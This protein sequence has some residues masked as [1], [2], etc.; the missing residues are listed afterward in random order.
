MVFGIFLFLFIETAPAIQAHSLAEFL[1]SGIW[2][3]TSGQ[4]SLLPML[5]GSMLCS[6]LALLIAI[7]ISVLTA[8]FIC[9]LS[10]KWLSNL[11]T[12]LTE[13]M[14]ATPSVVY[15]VWGLV[16]LVPLI[17]SIRAPGTSLITGS[18]I[19]ATMLIPTLVLQIRVDFAHTSKELRKACA[20]AGLHPFTAFWSVH[21][22]SSAR[23]VINASVLAMG[24]ALGETVALLMVT[25]NV[26]AVPRGLLDPVRTLTSNIALE[27]S[28]ALGTHR[29]ALFLSG[30]LLMVVIL[31]VMLCAHVVRLSLLR[32]QTLP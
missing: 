10:K 21:L 20:A 26:P 16:V 27:M 8:G 22:P 12:R 3:P 5:V 30:L 2:E 29:S 14:S 31:C 24:R 11:L 17:G 6:L 19:L 15:G 25:G 32:E 13:L 28:Y 23:G 1:R 9:F 18:L 4:Y 7:P